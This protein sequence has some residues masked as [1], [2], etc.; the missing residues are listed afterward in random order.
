[1]LVLGQEAVAGMDR[2]YVADLG[3]ADDVLDEQITVG[4]LR[5]A[6]ADRLI[7]EFQV[8]GSTISF[9]ANGDRFDPHL[10]ARAEN[11]QRDLSSIRNQNALK[12]TRG[13]LC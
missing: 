4:S 12:H 13:Y 11:P 3:S 5:R 2:L 8:V 6:D 1:M 10:A 9:T 7:G